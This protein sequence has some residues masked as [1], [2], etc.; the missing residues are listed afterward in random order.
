MHSA[1]D[2]NAAMNDSLDDNSSSVN[3]VRTKT[4]L[5]QHDS[6]YSSMQADIIYT[7]GDDLG[8]E[9]DRSAEGET[10]VSR[11]STIQKPS[12]NVQNVSARQR[13][14]R[15]KKKG[16]GSPKFVQVPISTFNC[17]H[18]T[19]VAPMFSLTTK[20]DS[21]QQTASI[22]SKGSHVSHLNK[23]RCR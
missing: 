21:R 15:N 23:E 16:E 6:A 20:F 19:D 10:S 7:L 22:V 8:P 2:V 12:L 13:T 17:G 5:P 4:M 3:H 18:F 9:Y 11:P 1:Y 14:L